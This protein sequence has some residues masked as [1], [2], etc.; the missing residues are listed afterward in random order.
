MKILT[1][2]MGRYNPQDQ[3]RFDALGKL[4][5]DKRPEFVALQNVNND[6][7]KRIQSSAWGTK[8]KVAH[9]LTTF[10]TR[11]KR[12]VCVLSTYPVED[13]KVLTYDHGLTSCK[14]MVKAYFI[15]YDKQKQ[16]HVITVCSTH[17]DPGL[18][19]SEIR[20]CQVNEAFYSL[21]DD[22]DCF[23][24]G[25][26]NFINDI[27]GEASLE[28]GWVDTWLSV[29]G[30]TTVNGHTYIPNAKHA[31]KEDGFGIQRADGIFFKS[32]RY[33]LDSVEVVGKPV[34]GASASVFPHFGVL[35]SFSNL[36]VLRRPNRFTEVPCVFKRPQ[37]YVDVKAKE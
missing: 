8:Y 34:A 27:D 13:C 24:A 29:P 1:M 23:V 9:P 30:N 26:F 19:T 22:Q 4:L 7:V 20:E 17:L 6:I 33:K 37:W 21:R 18:E 10:E 25:G 2:D 31:L 36:D 3:E 5:M 11:A 32:V 15:M 14:I 12:T 35:A 28:G 16:A